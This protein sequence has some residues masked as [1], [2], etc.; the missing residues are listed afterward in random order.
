MT[1]PEF[2]AATVVMALG[3]V[4]QGSIGFGLA[5]FAAPL[6]ALI[7][8]HLAPGPLLVATKVNTDVRSA[9]SATHRHSRLV[10]DFMKSASRP[11][12]L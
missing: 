8:P 1:V 10:T 2:A 7:D 3:S 5:L 11:T 4:L 12:G 9:R 6:L